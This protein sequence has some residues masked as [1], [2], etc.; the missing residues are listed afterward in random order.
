[1][2]EKLTDPIYSETAYDDAFRSMEGRCDD[3]LIPFV[4]H[5]FGIRYGEGAKIKRLRNE[6]FIEKKD[7]ADEKRITDSSFEIT[8][9]NVTKRFHLECESKKYDGTILVRVFEYDAQIAR[10]NGKSS[11]NRVRFKFPNSGILLLRS[12]GKVPEVAK[13]ELEMPD[14]KVIS[15]DV[16]IMKMSDYDIDDIF[17]DKLFMLIPF[18]IFN[19]ERQL[20]EMNLSEDKLD[21]LI[22]KYSYIFGRLEKEQKSGNLSA[23]STSAIIKLTY[24]VAY[25]LTMNQKK[26]QRKVGDYMGGKVLDL[27]EFR[28]YD[29]GKEDGIIVGRAEGEQ[30]RK[31]LQQEKSAL[32]QENERLKKELEKLKANMTN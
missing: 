4:G 27:P 6:Q 20:P 17:R 32:Q 1:M 23:L 5:M 12:S 11:I 28:I 14:E 9:K 3:I 15:Y 24:S 2:E 26:V 18:Y 13:I 22:E 16:P 8:D 29:Q 30:E 21:K 25:K 10:N 31:A 7:E 19:Y